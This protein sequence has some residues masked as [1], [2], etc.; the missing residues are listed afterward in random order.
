MSVIKYLITI[1]VITTRVDAQSM[2]TKLQTAC[3]VK[4]PI[5]HTQSLPIIASLSAN[6]G[7]EQF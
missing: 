7:N 6:W 2:I 1:V 4:P 5:S 3:D